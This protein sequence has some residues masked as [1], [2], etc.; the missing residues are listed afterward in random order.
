MLFRDSKFMQ[1]LK[2]TLEVVLAALAYAEFEWVYVTPKIKE[3]QEFSEV[4]NTPKL[5]N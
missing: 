2:R 4:Y 3:C 1:S 5:L